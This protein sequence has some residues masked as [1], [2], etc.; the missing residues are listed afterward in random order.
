MI[1]NTNTYFRY[2]YNLY[3]FRHKKEGQTTMPVNSTI[4]VPAGGLNALRNNTIIT[5]PAIMERDPQEG[6]GVSDNSDEYDEYDNEIDNIYGDYVNHNTGSGNGVDTLGVG[7]DT[8]GGSR[9]N[10]ANNNNNTE[11]SDNG[12]K[13]DSSDSESDSGSN[14]NNDSDGNSSSSTD[15]NDSTDSEGRSRKRTRKHKHHGGSNKKPRHN[16]TTTTNERP[17]AAGLLIGGGD[18][19]TPA[20]YYDDYDTDL[21]QRQRGRSRQR[22]QRTASSSSSSTSK[23][24]SLLRRIVKI[25]L[26]Q[27]QK[28]K[29]EEIMNK[30]SSR[31]LTASSSSKTGATKKPTRVKQTGG[32]TDDDGDDDADTATAAA[33]SSTPAAGN[34]RQQASGQNKSYIKRLKKIHNPSEGKFNSTRHKKYIATLHK[35]L[36]KLNKKQ[37][38]RIPSIDKENQLTNLP[39]RKQDIHMNT[40]TKSPSVTITE[41]EYGVLKDHYHRSVLSHNVFRTLL[42]YL[43]NPYIGEDTYF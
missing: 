2:M 5:T 10:S 23:E 27:L 8:A 39:L 13:H 19:D 30:I 18:D 15:S 32:T 9:N 36:S 24:K 22:K 20:D 28:Q 25:K 17:A 14:S 26:K 11:D 16:T 41:R 7:G 31:I 35:N 6:L 40:K 3:N 38:I 29:E 21:Q 33:A 34:R 43:E 1:L 4:A 42:P 37:M 12:R